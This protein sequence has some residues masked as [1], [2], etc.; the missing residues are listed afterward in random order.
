MCVFI[1]SLSR[2]DESAAPSSDPALALLL[3]AA[4]G[5]SRSHGQ[6]RPDRQ[7]SRA[8]PWQWQQSGRCSLHLVHGPLFLNDHGAPIPAYVSHCLPGQVCHSGWVASF[9]WHAHQSSPHAWHCPS[10]RGAFSPVNAYESLRHYLRQNLLFLRSWWS[11]V[12]GTR[13][14]RTWTWLRC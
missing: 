8:N 4:L 11:L 5:R 6:L 2:T 12:G 9:P 14:G 3:C 10:M 13:V 1:L 7:D